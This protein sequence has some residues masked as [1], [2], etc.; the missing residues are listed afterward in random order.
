[1]K[2]RNT[3]AAT[4]ILLASSV[5]AEPI[6]EFGNP[7]STLWYLS[8]ELNEQFQSEQ[9]VEHQ[10]P[11]EHNRDANV[12][13]ML[14]MCANIER[15]VNHNFRRG[16]ALHQAAMSYVNRIPCDCSLHAHG[17][18]LAHGTYSDVQAI[19]TTGK[20]IPEDMMQFCSEVKL[21]TVEVQS[22]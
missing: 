21:V 19:L 15:L 9:C 22:Q 6:L 1:M 3:V 7:N 14:S 4:L 16:W 2:Y 12:A 17:D 5:A 20:A 11:E 8:D 18:N 13:Y 10:I